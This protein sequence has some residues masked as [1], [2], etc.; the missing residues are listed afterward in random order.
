VRWL[1]L[2]DLHY[3]KSHYSQK[4]A[5]ESL[6][7]AIAKEV[8]G[9]RFD[10][11]AITGDISNSGLSRD[12]EAVRTNLLSPLY[13]IPELS[14]A[15]LVIVPGNHDI[16][17][18]ATTPSPW[19]TLGHRRQ[20]AF[21]QETEEGQRVRE[22]RS[23]G[24]LSFSEF[25]AS[26]GGI[27]VD[28]IK[29]VSSSTPLRLGS[30]EFA[31]I[32]VNTA[33]FSDYE[34]D[35]RGKSPAP[36]ESLRLRLQARAPDSIP[37]VFGHHP[38][39]WF[40]Q[41]SQR[42]LRA[43]LRDHNALYLHGHLHEVSGLF[44]DH[45][46]ESIGF[47]ASYQASLDSNPDTLYE[48]M[49]AVGLID[50]GV[51]VRFTCWDATHGMWVRN[52]RLPA[53]FTAESSELPG[54]CILRFPLS[55]GRRHPTRSSTSATSARNAQP[56]RPTVRQTV[57]LDQFTS[58]DWERL[59]R[60]LGVVSE[61]TKLTLLAEEPGEIRLRFDDASGPRIIRCLSALTHVLSRRE[62]EAEN[63]RLDMEDEY[64]GI[65]LVTLG[66]TDQEARSLATKLARRKALRVFDNRDISS[67]IYARLE[68]GDGADL[69]ASITQPFE[70]SLFAW[71]RSQLYVVAIADSHEFYVT[72]VRGVALDASDPIVRG[73][74]E[75]L[76]SLENARYLAA[77]DSALS[78]PS[79]REHFPFDRSAYL[80]RLRGEFEELRYAPLASLGFKFP[81]A[82]LT[83]LYVPATAE[84]SLDDGLPELRQAID[85]LLD[86]FDDSDGIRDQIRAQIAEK[87]SVSS[88]R[89][90][91]LATSFYQEHSNLLVLGDPG[92]GKSCFVKN[93]LLSYCRDFESE[94]GWYAKHVPIFVP[95]AEVATAIS[96]EGSFMQACASIAARRAL[97]LSEAQL[98]TLVKNGR[99]AFF[100]DGLDEV[101]S[102]TS[103]EQIADEI[104]ALLKGYGHLGN[105]VVVTSRP[106]ALEP[107]E[108][109][110]GLTKLHLQGLN[111]HE[112]RTLAGRILAVQ[113]SE[114]GRLKF[115][116]SES[117]GNRVLVERLV[118][119]CATKPGIGRLARNPLLLTLLVMIYANSGPPAA[120]KHRVYYEAVRT[121]V[122][123]RNRVPG[124]RLLSEADLRNRLG[125]IALAIY[126][127]EVPEIPTREEVLRVLVSSMSTEG[128]TANVESAARDFLQFVAEA[129]GLILLS[130]P[131]DDD[132][133]S[134]TRVSF[135][136]HSF[137]E[138]FAAVGL[139][140]QNRASDLPGLARLKR[141]R[142]IV[143]LAA[144]ILADQGDASDVLLQ[145]LASP[146][147]EDLVSQTHL[148]FA[149]DCALA[150]DVPSDRV[151]RGLLDG[152][153]L[154]L[155]SGAG[156]VDPELRRELADKLAELV[157]TSG[158]VQATSVIAEGIGSE[159]AAAAAAFV[160]VASRLWASGGVP[161]EVLDAMHVAC[162][163]TQTS[164]QVALL[165]AFGRSSAFDTEVLRGLVVQA[166]KRSKPV[167][168]AALNAVSRSEASVKYVWKEL[169]ALVDDPQ[170]GIASQ[171]AQILLLN[172]I[173]G[174]VHGGAAERRV[175]A[176][177]L[178]RTSKAAA[179]SSANFANI[180]AELVDSLLSSTDGQDR[181][182][183]I[184]LMPWLSRADVFVYDRLMGLVRSTSAVPAEIAWAL[185]SLRQAPD[186][187]N[188]ATRTD[189]D[190]VVGLA[191]GS[192]R[193]DIRLAAIRATSSWVDRDVVRTEILA[194]ANA[195]DAAAEDRQEALGV[196][197]TS[198]DVD[199][200]IRGLLHDELSRVLEPIASRSAYGNS[201]NQKGIRRILRLCGE[202]RLVLA[203]ESSRR[204]V[205][206]AD[207]FRAPVELR[208][209]AVR[210]FGQSARLDASSVKEVCRWLRSQNAVYDD[211]SGAAARDFV[212][213]VRRSV[214]AMKTLKS[215]LGELR[216]ALED[217]WQRRS[218]HAWRFDDHSDLR[219]LRTALLE[220]I[221]VQTSIAMSN[222]LA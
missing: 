119:D 63:L 71:H 131:G 170:H 192:A 183:G 148:L 138:Y 56:S 45:G 78:R 189:T 176:S 110:K 67:A 151:R 115:D 114:S 21:F 111:K 90:T 66:T 124:Q 181:E 87:Y 201:R 42:P 84:K 202:S 195:S 118:S 55:R 185:D 186:A 88:Q 2:T 220:S 166:L 217:A 76:P 46:V 136:H 69:L 134:S 127:S 7:E 101:V 188:L 161:P 146:R 206:I 159:D 29:E 10:V 30:R 216:S 128:S 70:A 218:P 12:F 157:Q 122:T 171:A 35:D 52:H 156:T 64:S 135:M 25:L 106:A 193:R 126:E 83:D 54:G 219:A 137:L 68:R 173:A 113:M 167:K 20:A 190:L 141:W 19:D 4:L 112:I 27:G 174:F 44:N 8:Q 80:A 130:H 150:G 38:I 117:E 194:L 184:R 60:L 205:L 65:D 210:L 96:P 61:E 199:E 197:A 129:T 215:S 95:L 211:A 165:S 152:V 77:R 182:I 89:D 93:E 53:T 108:V 120:K 203:R 102:L 133:D 139:L 85:E 155:K 207:D 43:L 107:I 41:G 48:N 86:S 153:V 132:S 62:V 162:V 51:H 79:E 175:V 57:T 32:C 222:N 5:L 121:L 198:A 200:D 6:V 23:R 58:D 82:K 104:G 36:V 33:L 125:A 24:F 47:G 15:K 31:I 191:R 123:V 140:Q 100:F 178:R 13:Q 144:G 59:I 145:I 168:Y 92:S 97:P 180:D 94:E 103:R 16:D 22:S 177:C 91:G 11:V 116:D 212:A 74:R 37:I 18:S 39:D 158:A 196:L 98:S 163:R 214:A 73:V 147:S 49:F 99:V 204:V 179:P 149:F 187:A 9:Y 75:A 209:D 26:T 142:E 17:C 28:P 143:E 160:D 213:R 14:A 169:L 34:Y 164:L 50:G 109:P 40:T 105:R 172:G 221:E 72:D 208:V 154:A 3:G 1:H 81:S